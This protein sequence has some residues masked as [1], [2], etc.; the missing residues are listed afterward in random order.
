MIADMFLTVGGVSLTDLSSLPPIRWCL[1]ERVPGEREHDSPIIPVHGVLGPLPDLDSLLHL[2]FVFVALRSNDCSATNNTRWGLAHEKNGKWMRKAYGVVLCSWFN[3]EMSASLTRRTAFLQLPVLSQLNLAHSYRLFRLKGRQL[4][5]TI[6][7]GGWQI[8]DPVALWADANTAS[9]EMPWLP[10]AGRVPQ[11]GQTHFVIYIIWASSDKKVTLKQDSPLLKNFTLRRKRDSFVAIFHVRAPSMEWPFIIQSQ[12][13]T[14]SPL[15]Q[16]G[17]IWTLTFPCN[18]HHFFPVVSR[19][20]QT[21]YSLTLR[22]WMTSC[23]LLLQNSPWSM[24][25]DSERR[26]PCRK[27]LLMTATQKLWLLTRRDYF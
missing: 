2:T 15:I 17:M 4:V 14:N 20:S 13:L 7:T 24:N 11:W 3:K 12:N 8:C 19:L 6:Q 22:G 23:P 27:K 21:G 25:I 9:A 16:W 18:A 26:C 1:E 10:T 5:C